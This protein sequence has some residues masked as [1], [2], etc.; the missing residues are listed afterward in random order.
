[1]PEIKLN[2]YLR[3]ESEGEKKIHSVVCMETPKKQPAGIVE[4]N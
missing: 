2:N 4:H 1:M 3:D